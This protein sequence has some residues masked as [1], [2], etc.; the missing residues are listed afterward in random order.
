MHKDAQGSSIDPYKKCPLLGEA[1]SI[2]VE[3]GGGFVFI[4]NKP[5][6]ISGLAG[7]FCYR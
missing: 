6:S 3:I 1:K 2:G 4:F 5:L 7:K